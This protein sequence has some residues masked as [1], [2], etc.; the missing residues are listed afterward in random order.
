MTDPLPPSP[1][2]MRAM[3]AEEDEL[4]THYHECVEDALTEVDAQGELANAV[5]CEAHA[6]GLRY[7]AAWGEALQAMADWLDTELADARAEMDK[8]SSPA[9]DAFYS[10]E[11]MAIK[12]AKVKL[13]ELRGRS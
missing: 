8:Q 5:A 11:I 2:Q 4:A 10:A 1:E 12:R 7:G 3:A 6:A 13:A 9:G